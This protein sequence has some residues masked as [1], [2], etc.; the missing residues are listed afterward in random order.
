MQAKYGDVIYVDRIFYRHFAIYVGKNKVIHYA[1]DDTHEDAYIHEA[2]IEEFLSGETSYKVCHFDLA[3]L[4]SRKGK[5]PFLLQLFKEIVSNGTEPHLYSPQQ[6][7]RRARK[8]IGEKNYDLI[9]NNCEHFAVWCKT[10]LDESSQVDEF[11]TCA[12]DVA[13]EIFL[14]RK[15]K[16]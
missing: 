2:P 15:S 6:T 5:Q 16:R 7:V 12:L 10:G 14:G 13:E 9:M 1:P 8:R 3:D 4:K 11:L